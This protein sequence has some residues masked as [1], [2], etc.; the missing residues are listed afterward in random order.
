MEIFTYH[1]KEMIQMSEELYKKLEIKNNRIKFLEQKLLEAQLKIEK[2]EQA[3]I[4]A[5][6]SNLGKP[7][8][9]GIKT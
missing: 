7:V 2:L 1:T 5:E 3:Q 8:G 4:A 6:L 9:Y